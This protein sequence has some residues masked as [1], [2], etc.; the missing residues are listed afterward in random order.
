MDKK[1][2]YKKSLGLW[3]LVSLGVG[4]TIGSGIFVVPGIAAGIA[5]PSSILSWFIAAISAG[6]VLLSLAFISGKF[7]AT[8]A[9][10]PVFSKL[11]GKKF[12][13]FLVVLYILSSILGI[14]TIASGIGQYL[15]FFGISD[16]LTW[17]IAVIIIFTVLNLIGMKL[18]GGVE[19][20]LTALKTIPLI[21]ISILLLQFIKPENFTPFFVGGNLGFLSAITIVYW[22]YTG[23]EISAIP[24]D[25]TKNKKDIPKSLFIVILIVTFVY[26]ILNIAL[27]GSVGSKTLSDS[28]VPI[29]TG[30]GKFFE[31]S[32]VIVAIIGIITM[33]SAMNA[34][35]I[36]TSRVMQNISMEYGI[37]FL[38]DLSIRCVPSNAILLGSAAT[39][40]LI[41][42]TNNFAVLA[43]TSVIAILL[44]YIFISISAFLLFHSKRIRIVA[45]LGIL[46]TAAI[47]FTFFYPN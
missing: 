40:A 19:I 5:G 35:M 46:S 20:L 24:A 41:L 28:P 38:Q 43:V 11:F 32:S 1:Q 27:I 12:S 29:A 18:S 33:M 47:L 7:P 21:I 25:E 14:A 10:Y 9:F 4:G 42:L 6:S 34:Y 26:L 44:P 15:Q 30:M 23:F 36:A 16:I 8:G 37:P 31:Y 2:G 13:L 45:A 17:E 22:S 39:I 3:G